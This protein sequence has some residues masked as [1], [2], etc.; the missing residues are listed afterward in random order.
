MQPAFMSAVPRP[1]RKSPSHEPSSRV[2]PDAI[3]TV[4]RWPLNKIPPEP[5]DALTA[6]TSA[7][8][9]VFRPSSSIDAVAAR[10]MSRMS[11]SGVEGIPTN[12]VR[13][14][15]TYSVRFMF[16][17]GRARC[18]RWQSRDPY[19]TRPDRGRWPGPRGPS[20]ILPRPREAPGCRT[21]RTS[22]RR[23][24]PP[25]GYPCRL[26]GAKRTSGRDGRAPPGTSRSSR[27]HR[28]E[29]RVPPRGRRRAP[30]GSVRGSDGHPV[31]TILNGSRR[32]EQTVGEWAGRE[33]T[34]RF[35]RPDECREREGDP[36]LLRSARCP[37]DPRL[38]P[39]RRGGNLDQW[40]PDGPPRGSGALVTERP[41][42]LKDSF[43]VCIY[44]S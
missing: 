5:L 4:S 44:Y 32:D 26:P 33:A 41:T 11:V 35:R 25:A 39:G 36:R 40:T 29:F 10:R 18:A 43:K 34:G 38:R 14:V 37:S 20:G 16:P 15:R 30:V 21:T 9:V 8:T 27:R 28:G 3:G 19:A 17:S 31:G 42:P 12:S 1:E 6:F 24:E 22:H 7:C 2:H 23:A 13:C